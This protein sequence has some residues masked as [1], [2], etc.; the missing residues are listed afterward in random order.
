MRDYKLYVIGDDGHIVNRHDYP[1]K[2]DLGALQRAKELCAKNEIEVWE[3][4]RFIARV[5]VGGG[6]SMVPTN[7]P[8][9]D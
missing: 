3:G 8:H 1:A 2:D 7:G 6:A 9:K 4:A 5:A